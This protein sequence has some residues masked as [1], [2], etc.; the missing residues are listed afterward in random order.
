MWPKFELN[1]VLLTGVIA[2]LPPK[3]ILKC[4][5]IRSRTKKRSGFFCLK[6]K[7]TNNQKLKPDINLTS[8]FLKFQQDQTIFVGE[9]PNNPKKGQFR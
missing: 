1:Q 4:T 3:K 8:R 9:D 6:S 2:P 7:T 5:E